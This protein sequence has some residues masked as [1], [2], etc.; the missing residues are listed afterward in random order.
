VQLSNWSLGFG[1]DGRTFL[2]CGSGC[3]P[4]QGKARTLTF[5]TDQPSLLS[6][7]VWGRRVMWVSGEHKERGNIG[8]VQR[9]SGKLRD[10]RIP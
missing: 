5:S 2:M 1:K 4:K 7:P 9:R 6:S 3:C 10:Y 8:S